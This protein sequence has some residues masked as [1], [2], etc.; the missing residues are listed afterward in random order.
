MANALLIA[1]SNTGIII[2]TRNFLEKGHA[3]MECDSVHS[4]TEKKPKNREIYSPVT[5]VEAARTARI[6]KEPY[7]VQYLEYT[8][9]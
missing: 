6:T 5:Y 1:S 2:T 3:Q 4:A 7:K 9:F 8:F